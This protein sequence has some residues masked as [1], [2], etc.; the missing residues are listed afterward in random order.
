MCK[1]D[2]ELFLTPE[3]AGMTQ[4]DRKNKVPS[5]LSQQET[6]QKHVNKC[7]LSC[8]DIDAYKNMCSLPG[9][10]SISACSIPVSEKSRTSVHT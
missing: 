5:I 1:N 9:L 6:E 3:I 2:T 8:K 7:Y 10:L 4:R